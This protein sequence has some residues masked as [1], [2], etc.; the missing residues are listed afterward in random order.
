[1]IVL[2]YRM[3][4]GQISVARLCIPHIISSWS[5]VHAK[6]L[7]PI[8]YI[9]DVLIMYFFIETLQLEMEKHSI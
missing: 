8:I 2:V 5:V 9:R 1:M 3:K 4:A 7:F 6:Y